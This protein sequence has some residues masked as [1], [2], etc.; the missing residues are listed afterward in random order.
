MAENV[1]KRLESLDVLRGL[2]IFILVCFQ[3]VLFWLLSHSCFGDGAAAEFFKT[4]LTHCQ[5]EGFHFW[6][7][8]MPLFLFMSGASIPFSLGKY[9]TSAASYIRILRRVFLLFVFGMVVQGGLLTFNPDR[10]KF[11]SNTLQSIAVGYLITALVFLNFKTKGRIFSGILIFAVGWALMTFGGDFTPDGNFAEKVDKLLMGHFRDGVSMKN[12]QWVASPNYHYTW[13]VSSLNFGITVMLGA[14][15]GCI[16]RGEDKV[17]NAKRL[18]LFSA[19]LI[20]GGL[21]LGMQTP[22]IKKIWSS[23]M[24]LYSGGI[25][26]AAMAVFYYSIDCC[27]RFKW[28]LWLK[29]YGMNSIFAYMVSSVVNFRSI[30]QSL[31]YGLEERLVFCGIDYYPFLMNCCQYF[32]IFA[33]LLYMYKHRIYLKV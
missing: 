14:F 31:L 13:I 24:T 18:L 29:I 8:I 21:L 2:D 4:Q 16:M 22:I 5:W 33:L 15:S 20:A 11:Y 25:C 1:G 10:F 12:G 7:L 30:P 9:D 3:P 27:G 32:V 19:A 6:D 23:S 26:V 17:A 28:L